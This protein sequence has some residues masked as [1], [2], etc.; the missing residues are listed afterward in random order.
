M[1][2]GLAPLVVWCFERQAGVLTQS[3]NGVEFAYAAEWVA[4]GMP[5]LSQSLPLNGRFDAAAAASFFGGLLPEGEPR[6]HL[7]RLL[8]PPA[9]ARVGAG[10]ARRGATRTR[11]TDGYGLGCADPREHRRADR[12]ASA[13]AAGPHRG[14]GVTPD[15]PLL[16]QAILSPF[17]HL[18]KGSS[19]SFP[20]S[21]LGG[22]GASLALSSIAISDGRCRCQ[23]RSPSRRASNA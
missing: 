11:A 7:A 5:P 10:R 21:E 17:P 8:G 12:P 19:R 6:R 18:R 9:P 16:S 20:C 13:V 2:E 14:E 1:P 3:V 15:R 23:S 4:D 22:A